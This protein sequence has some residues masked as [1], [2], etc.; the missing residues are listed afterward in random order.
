LAD[1]T[2][3]LM[4]VLGI[5]RAHLAGNSMGCQVAL[6]LARRYPE[7]AGALVLCGPTEGADIVPFW[8]TVS[9]LLTDAFVEPWSYNRTLAKM[10]FQMGVTRYFV[11]VAKMNA[12][13]PVL[14]AP[15][16]RAPCLLVRGG[17]DLI[18]PDR[19]ARALAARLPDA[20]YVVLDDFA[21][22]VQFSAPEP[23]SRI[24]LPFWE[25]ADTG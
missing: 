4:D 16:V 20:S 3:R 8:R 6:A 21:H 19:A 14:R 24:A 9:G 12:D 22:A 10:Y 11:T 2:V 23:L 15:E 17:R 5:G 1:W 18:V 13:D 7:R 25:R